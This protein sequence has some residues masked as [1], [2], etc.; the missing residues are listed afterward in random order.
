MTDPPSKKQK[1]DLKRETAHTTQTRTLAGER[2]SL[3]RAGASRGDRK[4]GYKSSPA[5][6][7]LIQENSYLK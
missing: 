2:A 5:K 6:T 1:G 7:E 4:R 3:G